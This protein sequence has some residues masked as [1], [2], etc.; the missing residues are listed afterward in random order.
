MS[1]WQR[2]YAAV[3]R[4]RRERA[5]RNHQRLPVPVISVGN[6]HWGGGG[7]TP[8]TAAIA[9]HLR[10]QGF[11]V[12]ILSRGHG[13]SSKGPLVVSHG[14]GPR[15]SVA[16]SGDEPA[17]LARIRGV[18]VVVAERRYAA[19]QLALESF[20]CDLFLLDDGF[21]HVGLARDVEILV[22]PHANPLGGGRLLPS[23]RLRE[24]LGASKHADAIVL[25]GLPG[26]LHSEV[27]DT[28]CIAVQEL[29]ASLSRAIDAEPGGPDGATQPRP[30]AF[31]ASTQSLLEAPRPIKEALL[32]CAVARSQSVVEGARQL[33][34]EHGFALKD[35]LIFRDHH[36]YP[37]RSLA[38][39]QAHAESVDTVLVTGKDLVK[40]DGRLQL[41]DQVQLVE[42]QHRAE[43]SA[44][45]FEWLDA[46][47][48]R[49]RAKPKQP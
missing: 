12:A 32:V 6:L 29:S 40:L 9:Q 24:P 26:R 21:S 11:K 30:R 8:V 25:T 3:L 38:K 41:L 43:L 35:T 15:V 16:Q 45:F 1:P 28:A 33:G 39:I 47:L 13:R 19:G 2:F 17:L 20:D 22:F 14:A 49:L 23:G 27:S 36:A 44:R 37:A 7:K 48:S 18:G 4:Q 10:D 34:A 31:G 42:I 46:E 5:T